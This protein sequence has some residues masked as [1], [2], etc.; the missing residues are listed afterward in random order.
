MIDCINAFTDEIDDV[1]SAV[2]EIKKQLSA[3][4]RFKD[5]L[6]EHSVAIV[7]A[8]KE[9][10]ESGVLREVCRAL[11]MNTVGMIAASSS[12]N[13]RMSSMPLSALVL[14]SSSVR[15]DAVLCDLAPLIEEGDSSVIEKSYKAASADLPKDAAKLVIGFTPT[16]GGIF[17]DFYAA[18]FAECGVPFFGSNAG[19]SS[20]YNGASVLFN[21]ELYSSALPYVIM[22]GDFSP[23]FFVSELP[24][25]RGQRAKGR[26]TSV[27]GNL[28]KTV[29]GAPAKNFLDELGYDYTNSEG[30]SFPF[31][32]EH[33]DGS[34]VY[35]A[36]W[37]L[38]ENEHM[39]L[40]GEVTAGSLISLDMPLSK[41]VIMDAAE[42][43]VKEAAAAEGFSCLLMFACVSHLNAL[44][45][46]KDELEL[47]DS[48]LKDKIPYL[49]SYSDGEYCPVP[50]K[51]GELVNQLHNYSYIVCAM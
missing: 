21:G 2:R 31:R 8:H 1:E 43:V 35:R 24:V 6:K 33:P 9:F 20:D 14:T 50:D 11:P 4:G 13:G 16:I 49:L 23:S 38:N 10:A 34:V 22:S 32:I 45:L 7:A 44:A 27:S 18:E 26:V 51:N 3:K 37:G 19:A 17:G 28:L 42:S 12:V 30:D 29:D 47:T 48:L 39:V 40:A 15:M 5:F 25:R 46:S 41:D 36:S